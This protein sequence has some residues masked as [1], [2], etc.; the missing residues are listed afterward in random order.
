M[1]TCVSCGS[2]CNDEEQVC[3]NCK[4]SESQ[5]NAYVKYDDD[6]LGI[7]M[8]IILLVCSLMAVLVMF[9][10]PLLILSALF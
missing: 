9:A 8:A 2:Y 1:N 4:N 3:D 10:V 5:K 6:S 7:V